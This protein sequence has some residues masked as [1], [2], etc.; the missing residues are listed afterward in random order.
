[1]AYFY[2]NSAA[3]TIAHVTL[4][5][6]MNLYPFTTFSAHPLNLLYFM[7]S[8]LLPFQTSYQLATLSKHE[9]SVQEK[10]HVKWEAVFTSTRMPFIST[11]HPIEHVTKCT[12][13]LVWLPKMSSLM[14]NCLAPIDLD[15]FRCIPLT[16]PSIRSAGM[17][18]TT[19]DKETT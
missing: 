15:F 16:L 9:L 17:N 1:M 6:Y 10:G 4:A 7:V 3:I 18:R 2:D 8:C 13:P 11:I 5:T 19:R 14:I 12:A